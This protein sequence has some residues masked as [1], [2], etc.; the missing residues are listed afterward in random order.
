[1]HGEI[2]QYIITVEDFKLLL[3]EMDESPKQKNSKYVAELNNTIKQ[4]DI[5]D[6]Y[7]ALQETIAK[8]TFFLSSHETFT[9]TDYNLDHETNLNKFKRTGIRT[10]LV[11]SG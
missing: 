8:Y 4:L 6:I 7:R 5:I 10:S 1:M 2:Y 11:S 3:S 9:K